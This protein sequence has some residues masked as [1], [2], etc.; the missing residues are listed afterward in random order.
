MKIEEA[1]A[2]LLEIVAVDATDVDD[3]VYRALLLGMDVLGTDT[4]FV[5][6][7][8]DGRFVV[9]AALG[10]TMGLGAG[11][12]I[13]LDRRPCRVLLSGPGVVAEQD[14]ASCP[15]F[16][17]SPYRS[18]I[19]APVVHKSKT[20]GTVS[21]LSTT[22]ISAPF[23]D[24]TKEFVRVFAGLMRAINRITFRMEVARQEAEA[25]RFVLDSVPARIWLKDDSNTIKVANRAAAQSMGFD[26]PRQLTD[27][28][29]YALFPD[30]AAGY[31]RQDL[32]VI[33]SGEPRLG[34]RDIYRGKNGPATHTSTDKI[35][36]T[37]ERGRKGVVI[38]STD[39]AP[40]DESKIA[41][42]A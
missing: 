33:E 22:L 1:K 14:M 7:V 28:D 2:R 30:L 32:E 12:D 24:D 19:G 18:F 41:K 25:F 37:D 20:I 6:H 5:S 38:I 17:K 23:D 16:P 13:A 21:F 36:F 31:H 26:D 8:R 34:I 4:A 35:P 11:S 3:M 39:I 42:K 15:D 29:T 10:E 27:V 40:V 9:R